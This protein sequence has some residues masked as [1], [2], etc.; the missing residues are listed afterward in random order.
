MK[1]LIVEDDKNI[2][3]I[4]KNELE[5][6]GYSVDTVDKLDQVTDVFKESDPQLVLM[7]IV[8][9]MQFGG[10]DYITKPLNMDVTVAK[11]QAMLRRAYKFVN[12]ID[13]ISYGPVNLHITDAKIAYDGQE[14]SLTKTEL[15]IAQSLFKAQG[16]VASRESLMDRCWQNDNF[17]D[18]NTLAVNINRLRKKL[19]QIGLEGLIETKKGIG[20]YLREGV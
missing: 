16:G 12:D 17:I 19:S 7:D 2:E 10:D 11:V 3:R 5:K 18:D 6:W 1:I 15:L 14:V 4:L 8:M 13:Y 9:A 20:Y